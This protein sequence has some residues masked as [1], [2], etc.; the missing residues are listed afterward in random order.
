MLRSFI[1]PINVLLFS[2][3][4][5][6]KFAISQFLLLFSIFVDIFKV[7]LPGHVLETFLASSGYGSKAFYFLFFIFF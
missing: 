5:T 4:A 6:F 1:L 3:I 7:N 2:F